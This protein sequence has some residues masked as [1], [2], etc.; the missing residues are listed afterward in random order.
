MSDT[1]THH[2]VDQLKQ[3]AQAMLDGYVRQEKFD[4]RLV[5]SEEYRQEDDWWYLVVVPNKDGVRLN[6]YVEVLM[7][8]ERK[9]GREASVNVLLVPALVE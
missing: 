6:E 2:D 5:V 3:R 9:L 8:V 1:K 4:F 7:V